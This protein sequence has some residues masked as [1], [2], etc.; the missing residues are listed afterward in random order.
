M[1]GKDSSVA[2]LLIARDN[3]QRD[4]NMK[5]NELQRLRKML[6]ERDRKLDEAVINRASAS[7]EVDKLHRENDRLS[8]E[9]AAL[10]LE[11][12]TS[13]A[14]IA[15]NATYTKKL[16]A[17]LTAGGKDFLIEQNTKFKQQMQSIKAENDALL[18]TVNMQKLELER[19]IKEIEILASALELR[20]DEFN[21]KGD[22]RSGLL[23]E[24]ATRRDEIKGLSVN[25]ASKDDRLNT[26]EFETKEAILRAEKAE[27]DCAKQ[28]ATLKN[29]QI[30]CQRVKEDLQRLVD[31][32]V[33]VTCNLPLLRLSVCVRGHAESG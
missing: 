4:I 18:N 15:E 30:E 2:S 29:L 31:V 10:R 8:K 32:R 19:A 27:T 17:R 13:D 5:D 16:E 22:L 24:I 23:Y 25:L 11:K 3:L 6:D 9:V 28:A 12:Q 14:S 33:Q 1:A 7:R 20:A 21:L 26:L